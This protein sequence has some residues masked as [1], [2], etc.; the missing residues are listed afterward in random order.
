M[1]YI[2]YARSGLALISSCF[3]C[4]RQGITLWR[5]WDPET[6]DATEVDE[7]IDDAL[8]TGRETITQVAVPTV[9][10][11]EDG[12]LSKEETKEILERIISL[13]DKIGFKSIEDL[14]EN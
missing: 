13:R 11:L 5:T 10:A 12:R 14:K 7:V 2:S 6:A 8:R 4:I 3:Y 1:K 9:D